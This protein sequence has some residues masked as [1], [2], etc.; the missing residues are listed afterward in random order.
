VFPRLLALAKVK[1]YSL[2][3]DY[4]TGF[5]ESSALVAAWD[6][7]LIYLQFK[8]VA[9]EFYVKGFQ[10]IDVLASQR[11]GRT[12]WRGQLVEALGAYPY[13]NGIVLALDQRHFMK[14][15]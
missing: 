11:L 6:R 8:A 13:Q 15:E 7:S 3:Y 14:P 10:V 12:S 1:R 5:A 9:L 2:G 4:V